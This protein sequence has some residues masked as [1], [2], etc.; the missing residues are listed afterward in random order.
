MSKSKITVWLSITALFAISLLSLPYPF[1]GLLGEANCECFCPFWIF[2]GFQAI[3]SLIYTIY[4]KTLP[5]EKRSGYTLFLITIAVFT[6]VYHL[7]AHNYFVEKGSIKPHP[8]CSWVWLM[9]L[10]VSLI[11][12][13]PSALKQ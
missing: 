4:Y 13:I 8:L 5:K 2:I 11:Y 9:N 1:V 6:F 12:L 7:L 10:V 3:S